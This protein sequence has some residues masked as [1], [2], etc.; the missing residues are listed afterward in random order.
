MQIAKWLQRCLVTALTHA[1]AVVLFDDID[2]LIPVV[3]E[4]APPQD[5]HVGDS[6][7]EFLAGIFDWLRDEVRCGTCS[8]DACCMMGSRPFVV[9]ASSH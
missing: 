9:Q 1:P 2:A 4:H 3:P 6:F 5:Q 8:A 7:V